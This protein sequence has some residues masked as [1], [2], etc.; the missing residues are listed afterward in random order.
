MYTY[1]HAKIVCC[2]TAVQ[3]SGH[4]ALQTAAAA[5]H[6]ASLIRHPFLQ[7]PTNTTILYPLSGSLP[8]LLY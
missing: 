2:L 8:A 4:L 3:L 1:M 6:V 5:K 7:S